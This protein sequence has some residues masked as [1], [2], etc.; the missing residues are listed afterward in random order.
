[1]SGVVGALKGSVWIDLNRNG[2]WDPSEPALPE[3]T[4]VA[5]LI[6]PASSGD[7]SAPITIRTAADGQFAIDSIPPGKWRLTAQLGT[8]AL[9]K[10]YDSNGVADWVVDVVVPANGTGEGKFAAAGNVK[11]AE[12]TV[13]AA[14]LKVLFL[15]EGA[16]KK[17]GTSDDVSFE[18]QPTNRKLTAQGMPDGQFQISLRDATTIL[19]SWGALLT[20]GVFR[21]N[22]D[23]KTLELI[24]LPAT[25]TPMSL[26]VLMAV[27]VLLTGL[28]LVAVRR[29]RTV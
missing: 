21:I 5:E 18:F 22:T 7:S 11:I 25:G 12:T 14:T 13:P 9:A 29:R 24:S 1:M 16:D 4:V 19:S 8:T 27:F 10:T 20:P 17:L 3:I 26:E 28:G 6:E 23:A 2:V 15:W